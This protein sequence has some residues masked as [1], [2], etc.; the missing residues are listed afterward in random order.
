MTPE[1]VKMEAQEG[2][3]QRVRINLAQS[4][5]GTVQFDITSEFPDVD[6]AVMN[7]G[8]AVDRVR[9]LCTEKGLIMAGAGV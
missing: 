2:N 3:E 1:G 6:Q 5:K 9:N 7:L 4:A 8:L